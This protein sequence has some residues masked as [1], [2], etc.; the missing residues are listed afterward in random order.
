SPDLTTSSTKASC[1]GVRLMFRV[2]MLRILLICAE[3]SIVGKLC[4]HGRQAPPMISAACGKS[5]LSGSSPANEGSGIR[6]RVFRG[7]LIFYQVEGSAVSIV[8]ILHGARDYEAVCRRVRT[9]N[10]VADPA[11]LRGGQ[12]VTHLDPLEQA[13]GRGLAPR[14]SIGTLQLS[15]RC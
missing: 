13:S 5:L 4:Q 7:D 2:G 1:S 6:R 8:R 11:C 9:I 10:L 15:V 3:V 12:E 14:L